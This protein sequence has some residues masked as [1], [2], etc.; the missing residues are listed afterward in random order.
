MCLSFRIVFFLSIG[1]NALQILILFEYINV[2]NA[3]IYLY[4]MFYVHKL[5]IYY[6]LLIWFTFFQLMFVL[7]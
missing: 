7:L 3:L 4:F 5:T 1:G 6:I 2:F